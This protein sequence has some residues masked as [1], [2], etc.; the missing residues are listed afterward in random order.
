MNLSS[1]LEEDEADGQY[2]HGGH[3][4]PSHGGHRQPS[5]GGYRHP[6][7]GGHEK[8]S[9]SPTNLTPNNNTHTNLHTEFINSVSKV[10]FC[11]ALFTFFS[12]E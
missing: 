2:N 5:P 1:V 3:R 4:Q 8:I 12:L 9:L 6:S 10:Y 7:P 11:T